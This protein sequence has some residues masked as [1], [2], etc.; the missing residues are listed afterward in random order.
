VVYTGKGDH[1]RLQNPPKGFRT[2]RAKHDCGPDLQYFLLPVG[3][4]EV[5]MSTV[6]REGRYLVPIGC[7]L[8]IAAAF[9]PEQ[10]LWTMHLQTRLLCG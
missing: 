4:I 9:G 2:R 1:D 10:G 3:P 6:L 8:S 7:K 5:I